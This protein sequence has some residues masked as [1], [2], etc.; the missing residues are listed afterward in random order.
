M[1]DGEHSYAM[2]ETRCG[3]LGK[4][5][6]LLPQHPPSRRNG[7]SARS[8]TAL[9]GE[10]FSIGGRYH[11]AGSKREEYV[12]EF[13]TLTFGPLSKRVFFLR[14][15]PRARA[16]ALEEGVTFSIHQRASEKIGN[17]GARTWTQRNSVVSNPN[18][19]SIPTSRYCLTM[20]PEAS[21]ARCLFALTRDQGN[22]FSQFFRDLPLQFDDKIR[23]VNAL[24]LDMCEFDIILGIDWLAAHRVLRL[25]MS[26]PVLSQ[27]PMLLLALQPELSKELKDQ[28]QEL[29]GKIVLF[30]RVYRLLGIPDFCT[31]FYFVKEEGGYSSMRLMYDYSE[32]NKIN[33]RKSLSPSVIDD[34]FD[35]LQ[36]TKHFSKIDLT[37]WLPSVAKCER[38][39][40]TFPKMLFRTLR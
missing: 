11:L 9:R 19:Y 3:R 2:L 13:L 34:L 4:R 28:L 21:K 12:V 7:F 5:G 33:I 16:R 22:R 1:S 40:R 37:I 36:G 26:F 23:S 35:Q 32:L 10:A 25:D 15:F 27:S 31:G 20:K 30:A 18:E 29:F 17:S 24:P 38:A 8:C 14:F 6:C 39:E